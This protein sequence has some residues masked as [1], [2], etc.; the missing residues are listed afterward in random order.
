MS[1][2]LYFID[3]LRKMMPDEALADLTLLELSIKK[4]ERTINEQ[5]EMIFKL[6]EHG[7]KNVQD[8]ELGKLLS[9]TMSDISERC[10]AAGW[11]DGTEEMLP[12]LCAEAI[13][14]NA[15]V[16]WGQDVVT[17]AE[18]QF[19]TAIAA[20]IGAWVDMDGNL[21]VAEH[22]CSNCGCEK[23]QCL[24][25]PEYWRAEDDEGLG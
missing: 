4:M 21:L 2:A 1:A 8:R 10:W 11:M 3:E 25:T 17:V 19:M 7:M 5:R 15:A 14:T 23:S 12:N 22:Y 13:E 6:V 9:D 20:H 24:C 16:I 18:A